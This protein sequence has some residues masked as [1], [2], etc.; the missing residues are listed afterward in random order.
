MRNLISA[1]FSRL[2][3]DKVFLCI[4]IFMTVG[5]FP[6]TCLNCFGSAG[7][8]ENAAFGSIFISGILFAVFISFYIG[9]EYEHGAIRNKIVVGHSRKKIYFSSLFLCCAVSAALMIGMLVCS[10][11]VGYLFFRQFLLSWKDQLF[12]LL[13]CVLIAVTFS[14]IYTGIAMTIPN[15]YS[16]LVCSIVF[17]TLLGLAFLLY[18][19]QHV[20]GELITNP[21]YVGGMEKNIIEF[22]YDLLPTGQM[23]SINEL[24]LTRMHRWPLFSL[25]LCSVVS[26]VGYQ[27]FKRKEI[28]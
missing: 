2:W 21:N 13:C 27:V 16:V 24:E 14:T 19:Q 23:A 15:K 28:K 8:V 3:K 20:M 22:L 1:N 26:M 4:L 11:I 6:I 12:V 18:E 5:S 7:Y 25:L 10:Y 9:A 17:I